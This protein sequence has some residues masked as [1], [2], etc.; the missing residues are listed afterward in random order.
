[1]NMFQLPCVHILAALQGDTPMFDKHHHKWGPLQ[2]ATLNRAI[3]NQTLLAS[4][5]TNLLTAVQ[6]ALP[7]MAPAHLLRAEEEAVR[8]LSI[9]GGP[10]VLSIQEEPIED[11]RMKHG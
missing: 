11:K 1:M 9:V 8:A 7:N 6:L 4:A 3:V 2:E 5:L 10:Q